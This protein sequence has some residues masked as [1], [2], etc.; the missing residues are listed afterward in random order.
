MAK[1]AKAKASKKTGSGKSSSIAD[2]WQ[3]IQK[4]MK[5]VD[6]KPY[7]LGDSF[8]AATTIRHSQFGLGYVKAADPSKITVIFESGTKSLVH[9]RT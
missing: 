5:E 4:K 3:D 1:A 9:N 2:E 7:K 8:S 6:A